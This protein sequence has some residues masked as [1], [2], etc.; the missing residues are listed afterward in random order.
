MGVGG[1]PPRIV[2]QKPALSIVVLHMCIVQVCVQCCV[3]MLV[4]RADACV[5]WG[6]AGQ[7]TVRDDTLLLSLI[8][9]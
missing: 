3:R 8:H 7:L 6:G 9:I 1:P 2:R 5:R 4:A